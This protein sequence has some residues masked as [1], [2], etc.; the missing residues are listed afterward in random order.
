MVRERCMAKE[1]GLAEL[2][3]EA[4]NETDLD[5]VIES[6]SFSV[7]PVSAALLNLLLELAELAAE[8]LDL[9][10]TLVLG[11]RLLE[12]EM[13]EDSVFEVLLCE[14]ET[15]DEVHEVSCES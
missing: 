11:G 13:P 3:G 12:E 4:D 10:E 14:K 15:S 9:G 2:V 7:L 5:A 6:V 8:L 1:A